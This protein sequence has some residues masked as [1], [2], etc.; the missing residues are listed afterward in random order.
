MW[1]EWAQWSPPRI[2]P[3]SDQTTHGHILSA[4]SVHKPQLLQDPGRASPGTGTGDRL[5]RTVCAPNIFNYTGARATPPRLSRCLL[6][7]TQTGNKQRPLVLHTH[8]FLGSTRLPQPR[9]PWGSPW[10]REQGGARLHHQSVGSPR[11]AVGH[12]RN[13]SKAQCFRVRLTNPTR[14]PHVHSLGR[15]SMV[16]GGEP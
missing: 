16:G 15:T 11:G 4:A 13:S 9:A 1:P 6:S 7:H 5:G 3:E 10:P 2:T 14:S 8:V 12:T